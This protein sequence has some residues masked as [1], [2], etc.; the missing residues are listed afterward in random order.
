MGRLSLIA[1]PSIFRRAQRALSEPEYRRYGFLR[2]KLRGK[3]RYIPTR[4][5]V[6]GWNLEV[7]DVASF[8]SAYREIFVRKIFAFKCEDPSPRILDLGANVGLSVLF[9][10]KLYPRARIVGFEADP[11]IFSYL[12]R[13]VHGNGFTDVDLINKAAWDR[14]TILQFSSTGADAGRVAFEDD[15][16]LI[17]VASVNMTEYL[18][19]NHFDFIKMD[20][21]GAEETILPAIRDHLKIV[22]WLC[23]E[24]HS[25]AGKKQSLSGLLGILSQAGFRFHIHSS[26]VSPS[27]FVKITLNC[28]FDMQLNIFAWRDQFQ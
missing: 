18:Q 23:V 25:K 6:N 15:S 12:R 24:Y 13:N 26:I 20:V 8:L 19:R 27:P 10:K 17:Q 11:G 9:F 4:V 2:L 16:H 21:E 1:V 5:R 14:E 22:K 7:P 28:G 3:P